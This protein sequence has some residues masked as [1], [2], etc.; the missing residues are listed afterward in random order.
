[1]VSTIESPKAAII[2][3]CLFGTGLTEG[4]EVGLGLGL[5]VGVG[6]AEV[7]TAVLTSF[8]GSGEGNDFAVN[9]F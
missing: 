1:M 6:A 5:G 8:G 3:D 9:E 2:Y 7:T 4:A